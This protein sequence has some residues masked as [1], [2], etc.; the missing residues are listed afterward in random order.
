MDFEEPNDSTATPQKIIK[1]DSI[2]GN[3][4]DETITPEVEKLEYT[5][6]RLAK[7]K[8]SIKLIINTKRKTV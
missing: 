5:E 7:T 2:H 4:V 6:N 8:E 3:E 1:L